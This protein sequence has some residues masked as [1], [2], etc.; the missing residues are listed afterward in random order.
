MLYLT[1]HKGLAFCN[2]RRLWSTSNGV[3]WLDFILQ[4]FPGLS[5]ADRYDMGN[6]VR[7]VAICSNA[8]LP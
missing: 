5:W 3:F 6:G 1:K 4:L 2:G 8:V 7:N